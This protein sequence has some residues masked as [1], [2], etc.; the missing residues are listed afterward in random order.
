M[1]NKHPNL[2]WICYVCKKIKTMLEIICEIFGWLLVIALILSGITVLFVGFSFVMSNF[3]FHWLDQ[4]AAI[5]S[6][7]DDDDSCGG[8]IK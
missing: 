8:Y 3:G 6:G 5:L 7:S 4:F 2:A 1:T